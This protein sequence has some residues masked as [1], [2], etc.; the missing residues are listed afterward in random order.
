MSILADSDSI[1]V[2]QDTQ[3]WRGMWELQTVFHGDPQKQ[4][5]T[6]VLM[7]VT[8][9]GTTLG[10]KGRDRGDNTGHRCAT[11]WSLAPA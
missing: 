10:R 8:S 3:P 7:H 2:V 6:W 11:G 1:P 4:S 5:L 9:W